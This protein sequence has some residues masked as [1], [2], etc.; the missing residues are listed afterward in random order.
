ME[1]SYYQASGLSPASR[2]QTVT[3]A[4]RAGTVEVG[5][6]QLHGNQQRETAMEI[7]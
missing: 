7:Q 1:A 5:C 4:H 3:A 6:S 2:C